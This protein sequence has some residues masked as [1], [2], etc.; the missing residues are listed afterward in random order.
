[1]RSR[2]LLSVALPFLLLVATCK[3]EATPPPPKT[4][5]SVSTSTSAA[6]SDLRNAKIDQKLVPHEPQEFLEVAMLGSQLDKDGNVMINTSEFKKG[7]HV[8]LTMRLRTSPA[9]LQTRAVF[10]DAKG[11]EVF[12]S[13]RQMNGSKVATFAI[14][15]P[16][17]PGK[18]HVTGYWGG[19]VAVDRDF[20]VGR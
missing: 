18:Y 14:D 2:H 16:L 15:D 17:K 20:T 11:K 1:M 19:N 9:G 6:P 7:E 3:R 5:T 4:V 10:T 8:C 13:M 12:S